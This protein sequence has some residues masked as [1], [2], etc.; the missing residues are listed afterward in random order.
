MNTFVQ[1][2]TRL[3]GKTG[4]IENLAD[5]EKA[6][7]L[8]I[9]DSH[10]SYYSLK[11]AIEQFGSG[12]D[13]MIFCGD[14]I[15]DIARLSAECAED[16][17]LAEMVPA[18]IGIVEGN[19]DPDRYPLTVMLD[20][21]AALMEVEVPLNN[22]IDIAGH[23]ILFTHGHRYSLYDGFGD[24][25]NLAS[26]FDCSAVFYGHTHVGGSTLTCGNIFALNPGSCARPRMGQPPC[27]SI[28]TI[29]KEKNYYDSVFYQVVPGKC[30]P[31]I[32]D[33]LV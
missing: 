9:S 19:N 13:A 29:E 14:G 6:V 8:V 20:S 2:A 18:V 5:L 17:K 32:P 30:V 12:C 1:N 15:N 3:L 11:T 24:L 27:F 22:T 31:Y 21:G 4:D 10:G 26:T 16:P 28:V 7:I 33:S 25:R 23:R